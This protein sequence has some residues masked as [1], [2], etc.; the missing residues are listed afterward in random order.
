LKLI[1]EVLTHAFN[2]PNMHPK[3]KPVIDHALSFTHSDK[4][5]WFRNY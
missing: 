5:I 1:R 3:A 2:V 4:K